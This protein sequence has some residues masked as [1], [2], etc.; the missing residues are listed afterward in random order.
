MIHETPFVGPEV[1]HSP[2]LQYLPCRLSLVPRLLTGAYLP[3]V[4]LLHTTP[5]VEGAVSLGVEVNILPA[6]VEAARARRDLVVAQVNP[7]MPYVY[8]DAEMP[9][10]AIDLAVEAEQPLPSPAPR[11]GSPLPRRS[12]TGAPRS[13]RMAPPCNWASA[14]YPTRCWLG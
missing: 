10:S 2:T 5:P 4:V 3:D 11:P 7:A 12:V 1:R 8:G 13:S 6:A 9:V 14:P